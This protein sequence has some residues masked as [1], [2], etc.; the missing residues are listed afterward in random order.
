M[1]KKIDHIGIATKKIDDVAGFYT[2]GLGLEIEHQIEVAEQ[3]VMTAFLKVGE[4]WVELLEAT[5]DESPIAKAVEKRGP[6]VHHICYEVDDIEAALANLKE[7]GY[8]LIDQTP[9]VGAHGKLIAFV[10]PK[11]A[12][13]VLIELAQAADK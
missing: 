5:S 12:G 2:D 4:T 9:R 13:G 3:K 11:T 7:K 8:T 1:I 6:G 10:H